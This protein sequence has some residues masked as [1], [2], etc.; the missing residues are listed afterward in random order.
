MKQFLSLFILFISTLALGQNRYI[1][2]QFELKDRTT[3][4]YATKDGEQLSLDLY[5]PLKDTMNSR[6]LIVFMHGGGFS[7][8]SPRSEGEVKFAEAA[9][10]KGYVVAQISYRLT[11][12]G[13]NFGCDFNAA[14]K[15]ETFRKAG[16]DFL[17]AV[18]FLIENKSRFKIDPE[19]LI[20][21]GSSAGA[22]AVL[23][24]VYNRPL[25]LKNARKYDH[26]NFNG[27]FSL[28]GA[29]L[30]ARYINKENA[31]PAVFFHGTDDNLV[32]YA[33]A[34]HHF[35]E[36]SA[37]GYLILDGSKTIA[38]RLEKNGSSYLLVTYEGAGHEIS[39]MPINEFPMVFSFFK[40]VFL[41]NEWQQT[42][43][44][45]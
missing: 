24:A 27:V 20:V 15:V 3:E 39:S 12:K 9:A 4:I 30:D 35:C 16:E 7:G 5:Q 25:L 6:P 29:L 41:N 32:P 28:A 40:E 22:E 37:P 10:K 26:L 21:G 31:V 36:P 38:E 17:D 42:H 14:G 44:L 1:E 23:N 34:P 45:K 18:A 43:V 19:K 33:T 13:A 2:D 8:G 11:R